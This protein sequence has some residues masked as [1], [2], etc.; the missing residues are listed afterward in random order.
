MPTAAWPYAVP[1]MR[2][3]SCRSCCA[4][5]RR[6]LRRTQA[7]PLLRQ[8]QGRPGQWCAQG[9]GICRRNAAEGGHRWLRG[10]CYR[11]VA[12]HDRVHVARVRHGR[13]LRGPLPHARCHAALALRLRTWSVRRSC[14]HG[15]RG[16][17]LEGVRERRRP[18]L[19]RCLACWPRYFAGL[20]AR[21]AA[22]PCSSL[23]G[24][25]APLVLAPVTS[26]AV[27][28]PGLAPPCP[29]YAPSPGAC[30][31]PPSS[32]VGPGHFGR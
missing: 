4:D 10:G 22:T 24:A 7:G 20:A 17:V 11:G 32:C 30:S 18:L 31:A 23:R 6:P 25:A 19:E 12:Q 29:R 28:A 27:A 15:G 26:A 13:L 14:L 5:G 21:L 8:P 1:R 16:L 2:P 3:R 9:G